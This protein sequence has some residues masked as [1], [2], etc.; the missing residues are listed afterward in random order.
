M[1]GINEEEPVGECR[2][3][4]PGLENPE[5]VYASREWRMLSDLEAKSAFLHKTCTSVRP[6]GSN[7]NIG[8]S[9]EV[10]FIYSYT[11]NH[12]HKIDNYI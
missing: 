11:P 12:F 1:S 4:G 5:A 7:Q 9:V 10:M 6:L 3:P 8:E 2:N